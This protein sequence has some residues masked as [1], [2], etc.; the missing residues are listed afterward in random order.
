MTARRISPATAP[1]TSATWRDFWREWLWLAL[2]VWV[3][4]G[5]SLVAANFL[6]GRPAL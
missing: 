1:S 6:L 3:G 5:L 4:V 2:A